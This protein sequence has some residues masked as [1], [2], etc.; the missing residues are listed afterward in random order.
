[1]SVKRILLILATTL[2]AL[3]ARAQSATTYY[4]T[5]EQLPDARLFLPAPPDSMSNRFMYDISQYIW[6]KQQRQDS[7]RAA[8]AVVHATTD[9]GIMAELFSPAFGMPLN[10]KTTPAIMHLLR[11]G[12]V[13]ARNSVAIPKKHYLRTRPF[14]YFKEPT[15]LSNHENIFNRDGSFPSSALSTWS[16][17]PL[18]AVS[19][20]LWPPMPSATP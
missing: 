16:R 3:L 7:L 12:V 5:P 8:I 18:E 2:F 20:P 17:Q 9:I 19:P 4:L 13:T 14:A 15:L 10:D 6:G 11:R 1:M